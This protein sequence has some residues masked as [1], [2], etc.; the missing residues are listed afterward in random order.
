MT[1]ERRETMGQLLLV[2]AAVA[3]RERLE[4]LHRQEIVTPELGA[5]DLLHQLRDLL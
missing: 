5:Q 4:F 2:L 3:V 1:V